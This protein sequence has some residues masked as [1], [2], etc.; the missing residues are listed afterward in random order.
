MNVFKVEVWMALLISI[1][2]TS[3]LMYVLEKYS[4]YSFF[5]APALYPY[6]CR[7][8]TKHPF[9]QLVPDMC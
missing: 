1:T 9:R 8:I 6:P 2:L 7:Y 3:I 4:P 5:K